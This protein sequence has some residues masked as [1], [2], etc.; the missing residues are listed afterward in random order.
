[1]MMM[2]TMM[3]ILAMMM[4]IM[5]MKKANVNSFYENDV[6]EKSTCDAFFYGNEDTFALLQG[7]ADVC[8][9]TNAQTKLSL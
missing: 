8:R 2:M 3:T 5:M 9:F 4:M 6:D 1:M 7:M